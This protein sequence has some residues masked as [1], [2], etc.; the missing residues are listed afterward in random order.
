MKKFILPFLLLSACAPSSGEQSVE[1][2]PPPLL[3]VVEVAPRPLPEPENL[4][5]LSPAA[6]QKLFGVPDLVHRADHAQ[7]MLYRGEMCVLDLYFYEET[8]G[9]GFALKWYEARNFEGAGTNAPECVE[10]LLLEGQV[11]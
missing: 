7:T 6:T 4:K 3:E 10:S 8:S 11:L 1:V 2:L 9:E 5:G